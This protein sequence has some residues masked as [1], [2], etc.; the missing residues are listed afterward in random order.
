[1]INLHWVS[2]LQSGVISG[3]I[4]VADKRDQIHI[5]FW[6]CIQF[7]INAINAEGKPVKGL[8]VAGPL[9]R[10][11]FGELMGLP[12]VSEYAL[13]IANQVMDDLGSVNDPGIFLEA[14]SRAST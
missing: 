9:A 6:E 1:M 10:G 13:F 2:R 8:Y 14:L 5:N 12:Q 3:R 7:F 11:T 4:Q